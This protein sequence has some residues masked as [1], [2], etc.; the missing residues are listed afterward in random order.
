[1]LHHVRAPDG[2]ALACEV[3]GE[4][5]PIVMVHGAGSARWSFD[6]VRPQLEPHFTVWALNRRGRG[7]SEDGRTYSIEQEFEDVAAVVRAVGS[8]DTTLFGHSY[9]GLVCAGA[10]IRLDRLRRLVLYEPPMGG[11][12]ADEAWIQRFEDR[13]AGGE[14]AAAVREFL[15]DIGGYTHEEIDGMEG[16][17]AWEARLEVA[18]TVPRE[19]RAEQVLSLDALGLRSLAAVPCV[20][21][22]GSESPD[23]AR[24]STDAYATAIDGAD[25]R[26]LQGHGHGAAVSGPELLAAELRRLVRHVIESRRDRDAPA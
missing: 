3:A 13:I 17:P 26:T 2:V 12:L 4:G 24:R 8:D 10:A 1:M 9:G 19:L 14:R 5:P 6:L 20:L 21:L 16:T 7:D 23:W 11:V 18:P 25:V 22:V 15:H